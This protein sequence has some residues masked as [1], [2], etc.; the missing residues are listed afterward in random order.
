M[1]VPRPIARFLRYAVGSGLATL[2][3]AVAF[4]LAYRT[5][6]QGPRIATGAAFLLPAGTT[7]VKLVVAIALQ[8]ATAPVAAYAIGRAGYLSGA[9]LWRETRWDE[10]ATHVERADDP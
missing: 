6:A 8:L 9:P 4:A 5:L 10:L 1:T 7:T 2:V 3:S